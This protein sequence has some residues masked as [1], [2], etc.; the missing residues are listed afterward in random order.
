[1]QIENLL[2]PSHATSSNDNI[3]PT[4]K[5]DDI[6]GHFDESLDRIM[7]ICNELILR[8]GV[9]NLSI[10]FSSSQ[11]VC[12]TFDNPYSYQV[13]TAEEVFSGNFMRLSPPLD[14]NLYTCIARHQVN[15]VLQSIKF[16]RSKKSGSE[17]RNASVNM[18]NGYI[19]LSFACDDT[20]YINFHN[21]TRP[22]N[23]TKAR[24]HLSR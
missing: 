3:D 19:A 10:H 24:Q 17:L 18:M 21:F 14:S 4:K 20:R 22:M 15:P 6:P 8:K 12:W 16:L 11:L 9:F 2:M 1:M 7:E 23:N 5:S 13:Y